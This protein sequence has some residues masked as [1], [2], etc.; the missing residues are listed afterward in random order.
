MTRERGEDA[1]V[2]RSARTIARAECHSI[3]VGD[4]GGPSSLNRL[5]GDPIAATD[6]A[7]YSNALA[8]RSGRWTRENLEAYLT[9]PS[10][11][12]PGTAM[13]TVEVADE[14]VIDE[15]IDWMVHQD[16]TF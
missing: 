2:C 14:R 13:P 8:S 6:F 11:F 9:D 12:A 4:H 1:G 3:E 5:Y 15:I 10:G 16:A 7:G